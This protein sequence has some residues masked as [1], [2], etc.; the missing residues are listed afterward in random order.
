MF[1]CFPGVGGHHAEGV[2]IRVAVA[3]FFGEAGEFGF[4]LVVVFCAEGVVLLFV[5]TSLFEGWIGG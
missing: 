2:F 5:S 3:G 1:A 4:L